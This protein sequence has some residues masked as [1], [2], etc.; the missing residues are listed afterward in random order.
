MFVLFVFVLLAVAL[1]I[2]PV[3]LEADASTRFISGVAGVVLLILSTIVITIMRLYRKTSADE[4]FVR[5]GMGGTKII[6]DGGAV[7]APVIHQLVPVSLRSMKLEVEREGPDALITKDNLRV[8]IK[9]E[10]YI[11]VQPASDEILNASRSLGERSVDEHSVATLVFE[12]LVSVLRS[13]A[14]TKDLSELHTKREEFASSVQD[15][16]RTDLMANGL[17]LESVT[18]SRLDQ[19]DTALLSDDNVFDAQGKKKIAEVTQ[20]ARVQRN[21]IERDAE[22]EVAGT[23]VETRKRVLELERQREEA[24]ADQAAQVSIIRAAKEREQRQFAIEQEELVAKR[25]IEREEAV[26]RRGVER[27]EAVNVQEVKKT[28]AIETTERDKAIAIAN[29]EAEQAKAEAEQLTAEAEREMAAQGVQLVEVEATAQREKSRTVIDAQAGAE[30]DRVKQEM[31]ANI[32]AYTREKEAEGEAAALVRRAEGQQEA[33]EREAQAMIRRAEA[34]KAARALEAEG[35]RAEE[36]VP[37]D[38]DRERVNVE[39]ARVDVERQALENKQ[40]YSEAAIEFEKAKLEIEARRDIQ[41]AAANAVGS[42]LSSAKMTIWG[43]PNTAAGM[44]ERFF[45]GMGAGYTAEGL[46]SSLPD[47]AQAAAQRMAGDL[48]NGLSA[49]L[50]QFTGEDVDEKTAERLVA[51]L[52]QQ[53]EALRNERAAE[54][55]SSTAPRTTE[56][57]AN[58]ATDGPVAEE[59]MSDNDPEETATDDREPADAGDPEA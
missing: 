27:D 58:I 44:A 19:T 47:G 48:G 1:I 18:I 49:I 21:L 38:V 34:G 40:T 11:R 36:I 17:T 29:R 14:A 4:A 16:V 33:A 37:V 13:V 45:K 35:F 25:D 26:A 50:K 3:A 31:E 28:Q 22:R 7:V 56:P 42:M 6:L 53:L 54:A 24:E 55:A 5:T 52:R 59:T 20:E 41:I 39:Q 32:A 51:E 23:D 57:V 46:F 2:G 10:F 12:K 9:A 43:D 15:I 8:D 30:Q